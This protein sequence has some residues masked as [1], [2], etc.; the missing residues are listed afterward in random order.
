MI[1]RIFI[2]FCSYDLSFWISADSVNHLFHTGRTVGVRRFAV[3]KRLLL[4]VG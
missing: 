2:D 1:M 4:I 3:F